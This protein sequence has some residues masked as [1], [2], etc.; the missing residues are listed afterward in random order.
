MASATDY[1][2]KLSELLKGAMKSGDKRRLMAL[3]ALKSL[4]TTER[5]RKSGPLEEKDAIAALASYKKKMVGALE[6]YRDAG[7]EE[8]AA[9]AEVEIALCDELLPAQLSA[10]KIEKLVDEQIAAVGASSPQDLGKVMGP[11]MKKVAGQADGN[12]VREIV[13]RKLGG[14]A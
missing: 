5:T 7:R 9:G 4:I 13:T 6:Q 3:R 12:L 10:E 2:A 8:L 1:E 14:G 11:V